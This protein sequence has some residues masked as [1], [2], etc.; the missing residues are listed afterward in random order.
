MTIF[1]PDLPEFVPLRTGLEATG[2][3]RVHA[4]Q[5]GYWR[6]D[7]T[8]EMI[9]SRRGLGLTP[10]LWY[11]ALSGGFIGRIVRFDRDTMHIVDE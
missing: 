5:R 8:K 4:P 6:V 3:C 7:A 1:I 11:S 9:L 10:A 2:T